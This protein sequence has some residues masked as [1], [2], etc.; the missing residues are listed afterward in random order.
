MSNALA[1]A[2]NGTKMHA[3][4]GWG[5]SLNH[6]EPFERPDTSHADRPLRNVQPRGRAEVIGGARH[7]DPRALTPG[8][9]HAAAADG[10]LIAC[11]EHLQVVLQ[12]GRVESRPVALLFTH[13]KGRW[14][15]KTRR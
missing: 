10:H 14:K 2:R 3:F 4:E 12:G 7:G 1:T 15:P 6:V 9:G 13:S 11:G 8:E 5:G